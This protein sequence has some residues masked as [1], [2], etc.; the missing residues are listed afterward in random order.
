ML[1]DCRPRTNPRRNQARAEPN[2]QIAIRRRQ[3]PRQCVGQPLVRLRR[4]P[5]LERTDRQRGVRSVDN[6][7][8]Q[9]PGVR[10][11]SPQLCIRASQGLDGSRWDSCPAVDALGSN[12]DRLPT[13]TCA[14]GPHQSCRGRRLSAGV[15][16]D[17]HSGAATATRRWDH[18][19]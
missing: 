4:L 17:A 18:R 19:V 14:A 11:G 12:E 6:L 15:R 2:R 16:S 3:G 7:S 13:V 10:P 8:A 5:P 1:G 9:R